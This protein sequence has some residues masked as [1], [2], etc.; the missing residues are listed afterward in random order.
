M[1]NLIF[2]V[3]LALLVVVLSCK[4]QQTDFKD[5]FD[6]HEIVYT[7]SVDGVINRPGNLRTQLKWKSS[8]DPSIVKYVIYWNNKR[9]SQ[10]VAISGKTD[11]ISV[12]IPK[13]QEFVYSFTIY[14]YDAKGNKSIPKQVDNV[15]V[16][17]PIYQ[18]GLLNRPYD[19]NN[20][21]TLNANGSLVLNFN[22]PDTININT[23]I[24]YTN[25]AGTVVEK[26]LRPDSSSIYLRDYKLGTD[27]QYLSSY[28]PGKG[29]LDTFIVSAYSTFPRIY[30]YVLCDRLLFKEVHL[31]ND[32]GTYES[33]TS[34]S[35]LWDGSVGPQ[36]YP[37][38]FHSDGSSG[39]P[40]TITFDLGKVYDNLARIEETGR[41]CCNN[42]DDFEVWGIADIT[43]AATNLSATNSGWK[44]ESIAKGWTLL[45]EV[46]RS[47]DGKNAIT[48][49]L[50]NNGKPIR[51]I[52]IRIKHVTTGDGNYSN[53][54]EIRFWNK[55]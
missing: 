27:V 39:M 5:F 15:K 10:I 1:K 30:S 43:N 13:L 17:G 53:M 50:D 49:D 45:K 47:D 22:P 18:G 24:K 6:G 36:G 42:P 3:G 51:Y 11:S 14:S 46:V 40:H 29:S 38:I 37:N 32:A 7:G 21:Y 16:Y 9:D 28:I 19:A 31:P 55:Q 48:A 4:K 2:L 33:G 8:T 12:I 20:P 41:D 23:V 52:R 25:V 34:I 26:N 35:K 54:S 44:D